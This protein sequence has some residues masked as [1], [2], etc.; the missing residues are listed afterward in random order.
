M[1]RHPVLMARATAQLYANFSLLQGWDVGIFC[2]QFYLCCSTSSSLWFSDFWRAWNWEVVLYLCDTVQFSFQIPNMGKIALNFC[3]MEGIC[4]FVSCT[5]IA[6]L[7]PLN[8]ITRWEE[9]EASER[10]NTALCELFGGLK[11]KV[12]TTSSL[13]VKCILWWS[14]LISLKDNDLKSDCYFSFSHLLPSFYSDYSTESKS[15]QINLEWCS[16]EKAEAYGCMWE[17]SAGC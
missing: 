1:S 17:W 10:G 13:Y 4:I 9:V 3:F 14:F 6:E 15:Q 11:V 5:S 8:S 16:L 12:K 2:P 7:G